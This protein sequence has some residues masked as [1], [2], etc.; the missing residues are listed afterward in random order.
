M[1][2]YWSEKHFKSLYYQRRKKRLNTYQSNKILLFLN[3]AHII[4]IFIDWALYYI[5]EMVKGGSMEETLTYKFSPCSTLCSPFQELS[6]L[7]FKTLKTSQLSQCFAEV[8]KLS[9]L[10][11][12]KQKPVS[13]FFQICLMVRIYTQEFLPPSHLYFNTKFLLQLH[14]VRDRGVR[15]P[16]IDIHF[17]LLEVLIFY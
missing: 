12:P 16:R 7:V 11:K 2:N 1:L 4:A 3:I 17:L 14:T 10:E 5:N 15:N 9:C 6:F 8:T 13:H